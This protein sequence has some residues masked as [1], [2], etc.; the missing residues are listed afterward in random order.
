MRSG[1]E[2][3]QEEMFGLES[4]QVLGQCTR[5]QCVGLELG[6]EKRDGHEGWKGEGVRVRMRMRMGMERV[7]TRLMIS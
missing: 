5:F 7:S 3:K 2:S 1:A 4:W 6:Y